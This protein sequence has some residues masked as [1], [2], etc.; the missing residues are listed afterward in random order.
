ML[1]ILF[2]W[3]YVHPL[4]G[5][6][7]SVLDLILLSFQGLCFAVGGKRSSSVS[8]AWYFGQLTK[9]GIPWWAHS[10]GLVNGLRWNGE[11]IGAWGGLGTPSTWHFLIHFDGNALGL[12]KGKT[13]IYQA[14]A[15]LRLVQQEW[16]GVQ[17]IWSSMLPSGF[18]GMPGIL[19]T[20]RGFGIRPIERFSWHWNKV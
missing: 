20:L 11:A 9:P 13:V 15:D 2:L 1:D 19:S 12:V 3:A 5:L 17:I 6:N 14:Q 16:L 7:R 4:L 8:T 10:L 18:D